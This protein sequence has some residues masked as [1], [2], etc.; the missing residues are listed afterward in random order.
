MQNKKKYVL[1]TGMVAGALSLGLIGANTF[2]TAL[3]ATTTHAHQ[4]MMKKGMFGM[5]VQRSVTNI[6]DGIQITMTS[7]DAATVTKLQSRTAPPAPAN[8]NVTVTQ[9]NITNGVQIAVTSTDAAT[10]SKLQSDAASG[11]G[12]GFGFGGPHGEGKGGMGGMFGQN[13]QRSVTNITN[14][15]Q[16]TMTST[17]A[18]TVTKLQSRKVPTPP[19]NS[20]VSFSQ[21]NITNGI[22]MTI[23]STDAA[24]VTKLQSGA[25]GKGFGFGFGG[26][27]PR[28]HKFGWDMTPLTSPANSTTNS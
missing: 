21:T 15:I 3:A 27:R 25:S 10:V 5:N 16:V 2:G 18:A 24:T 22:Q 17:D 14:G 13:V 1:A 23:T 8:S 6:A 12:F 9:T 28:G 20:L 11:H 26:G 7:T 19:A 4:G